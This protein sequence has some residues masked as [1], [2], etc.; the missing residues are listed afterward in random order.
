MSL[1]VESYLN[2][3]ALAY[4]DFNDVARNKSIGYLVNKKIIK[5][6]DISRSELSP[7]TSPSNPLR[8]WILIDAHTSPSGMSVIAVQNPET[9]EVV[10]AYRGTKLDDGVDAA[11]KDLITDAAIVSSGNVML[12]DGLNQFQNAFNFYTKTL[13]QVGSANIGKVSFT[14]HRYNSENH[15]NS[16]DLTGNYGMML[17]KTVYVRPRIGLCNL[18]NLLHGAYA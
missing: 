2:L 1:N 9:K 3:S 12:R 4:I 14:G 10:F 13:E 18:T 8:A 15:V 7:L 11:I 5:N 6:E 17:G 16:G